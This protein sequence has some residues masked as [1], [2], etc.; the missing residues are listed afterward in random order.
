LV[1]VG[2]EFAL[3]AEVG[4]G[5]TVTEGIPPSRGKLWEVFH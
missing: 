5:R 4:N 1:F 2:D 3:K